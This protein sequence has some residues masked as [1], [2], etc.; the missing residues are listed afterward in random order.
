MKSII[1]LIFFTLMSFATYGAKITSNELILGKSATEDI[2]IKHKD[3]GFLKKTQNGSWFFSDDGLLEKKFG[4]GSGSGGSG[5]VNV[6]V[7][8]SFE[9]GLVNWT[10][11]GGTLTQET[12]SNSIEGNT[13]YA[14][15]VA[16][17][18]GQYVETDLTTFAD[19]IS[20]GAMADFKYLQADDAFDFLII[21]G[22]ANVISSQAISD[23][24]LWLKV[25]TA[26]FDVPTSAKIRIISTG[27][28]TID[29]DE[30]YLGSNKGFI[31]GQF[32]NSIQ[33]GGNDAR[34]ISG[35]SEDIHFSGSG[36]GWTSAG[37]THFYTV[38]KNN[39]VIHIS[40]STL[41]SSHN[42]AIN[43][44]INGTGTKRIGEVITN[45]TLTGSY[46]SSI[47]EFAAGDQ[48]SFR[49][50]TNGSTLVN[51][52]DLHYL[53]IVEQSLETLE[54]FTPE[55]A[56]FFIDVNIGGGNP[57]FSNNSVPQ[58]LEISNLDMVINVGSAKIPCLNNPSTGLTCSAGAEML[59]I[60][61]FAPRSGNYKICA[62]YYSNSSGTFVTRLVEAAL[63][64]QAILQQGNSIS[65][66]SPS[67]G[68][69]HRLCETF[70]FAS[71]GERRV[72]ILYE[73]NN[74]GSV[75]AS[76]TGTEYER[77]VHIT[78]EM[79]S[80]N[81]SRPVIQNMVDTLGFNKRIQT[82]HVNVSGGV[83]LSGGADC[84]TW[85]DSLDDD[86]VG[87]Y[88]LNITTGTYSN[89]PRCAV[90]TRDSNHCVSYRNVLPTSALILLDNRTCTTATPLDGS[91]D[92]T[93]TGKR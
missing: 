25:P 24:S 93:C 16:T 20:G 35:E 3:G 12:Y 91:F 29:F 18:A 61:F 27:A 54:A 86:G 50:D 2:F 88:G 80:H 76:R 9:D 55:Q 5:G 40:T 22:G 89:V 83:P 92:I 32:V 14:R 6:L 69:T 10:N 11:S 82:C 66:V 51:N 41:G 84:D 74:T 39:S 78:V 87:L 52:A 65:G 30:A 4:S 26:T 13:K 43:L 42:S 56:D 60:D 37:D 62:S 67:G 79:V 81:V 85:I 68:I 1:L 63:N 8:S 64:S 90:V 46:T 57:P 31:S 72:L 77:D 71:S 75:L 44:K 21:D 33:L 23:I 58:A 70:N 34:V 38:Q 36:T 59:G 15:F 7:N 53:S 17:G 28:G 48:L 47:G 45:T 49:F 19:N 73:A